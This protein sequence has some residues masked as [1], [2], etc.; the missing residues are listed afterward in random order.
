MN[1][2][3]PTPGV[4]PLAPKIA[5][6]VDATEA[7]SVLAGTEAAPPVTGEEAKKESYYSKIKDVPPMELIFGVVQNLSRSA[8][9]TVSRVA[10][11]PAVEDGTIEDNRKSL[12][13]EMS[14]VLV[15]LDSIKV[16]MGQMST[17]GYAPAKLGPQP[18]GSWAKKT[19]TL[20][21][22]QAVVL[23]VKT[24]AA[25]AE[26]FPEAE[27]DDLV[28]AS[29]TASGKIVVKVA[30]GNKVIGVLNANVVAAKK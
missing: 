14:R 26:Y 25:Y 18:K 10:R 15:G 17:L 20:V 8:A 23:N 27:L 2:K 7:Q 5:T 11:L 22:G 12:I 6:L 16:L 3:L 19:D 29:V 28:V 4:K 21:A 30:T 9:K 1:L 13:N 24:R